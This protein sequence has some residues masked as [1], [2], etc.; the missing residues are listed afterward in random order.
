MARE[1]PR[2]QVGNIAKQAVKK[3]IYHGRLAEPYD[4]IG[5][6][7][8]V[9]LSMGSVSSAYKA[10]IAAGDFGTGTKFPVGTPV[11][12]SVHRG[13]VEILSLGNKRGA[14]MFAVTPRSFVI[15]SDASWKTIKAVRGAAL[16]DGWNE[17]GFDDSGWSAPFT[18]VGSH[19]L[20]TVRKDNVAI[21]NDGCIARREYEISEE[22]LNGADVTFKYAF[23]NEGTVYINGVAVVTLTGDG[24]SNWNNDHATTLP[25]SYF[26]AGINCVALRAINESDG[27]VGGT[28]PAGYHGAVYI[29]LVTSSAVPTS[30][31]SGSG[32]GGNLPAPDNHGHAHNDLTGRTVAGTH[33]ASAVTDASGT[34]V[35]DHIDDDTIH[36]GGGVGPVLG[37]LTPDGV[38]VAVST[39]THDAFAGACRLDDGRILGVWRRGSTHLAGGVIYGK[40]GTLAGNRKSVASWGSGFTIYS[41]AEDV[42]CED[43]VSIVDGQIVIYARL[44]NGTANHS[45]FILICNDAPED[46]TSS[47][48]WGSPISVPLTAYSTQNVSQGYIRKL[49]SGKY[50]AMFDGISGSNREN[51]ILLSDSLTDWSSMTRTVVGTV[52]N[53][54]SEINIV[55][56]PNGHLRAFLRSE[57]DEM[58]YT[59]L[60]EDGGA[61]WSV[62]SLAYDGY[63]YPMVRRLLSGLWLTIYR[64]RPNGDNCWR[65]SEDGITWSAETVLD[66]TGDRSGYATILQLTFDSILTIYARENT[67]GTTSDLYSQ[68]FT[69][70]STAVTFHADLSD[71]TPDQ[72]HARRHRVESDADHWTTETDTAKVLAP[73]GSGGLAFRAEL[74]VPSGHYE[75]V[76]AGSGVTLEPVTNEAEDDWVYGWVSD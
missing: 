39:G 47:S 32:G 2:R 16:P 6:Y 70:S 43:A 71:V 75:V 20:S 61:T 36:G 25:R 12:I 37:T 31:S 57:T 69:D 65:S 34:T 63:G 53:N 74:G 64:Q 33:P 46:F 76:M 49:R 66:A 10:R 44:Y 4:G 52:A 19:G 7:V 54:F 27:T 22:D 28:P 73:N 48:T 38:P 29:E 11:S 9:S 8:L 15:E 51:G 41:N 24:A 21:P 18:N 58:T 1:T 72:H 35:Q 62:A 55:E 59:K 68:I 26:Q 5:Q 56:I 17:V 60:S 14:A 40:I 42:R 30:G 67:A 23:D 50:M 3:G 13:R 45:P